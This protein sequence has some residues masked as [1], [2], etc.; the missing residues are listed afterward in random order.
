VVSRLAAHRP[1]TGSALSPGIQGLPRAA[2][3]YVSGA[4]LCGAGVLAW[5]F[6]TQPIQTDVVFLFLVLLSAAL[7]SR[8]VALGQKAEM[9][10]SL[11]LILCAL[12]RAGTGGAIDVAVV[13]M[14]STCL[15]RKKPLA[16]HRTLFNIASVALATL[17]SGA[18]YEALHQQG[19]RFVPSNDLFALAAAV[20]TYFASNTILVAVAIS[21]SNGRPLVHVWAQSFR[22]TLISYLA[23][24]SIAAGMVHLLESYGPYSLILSVP[25]ILLLY[26]F[27]RFYIDRAAEH[28]QRMEEI[29]RHNAE[30]ESEVARRTQE[31][32]E[33]NARLSQ[34]NEDLKR[35]NRLKSEFLANMSHELRTPLNAIIGFSELLQESTFGDLNSDQ[36]AFVR[37]IHAGGQHLLNLINDILDL[38]KIEAGRMSVH[39]E[40]CDLPAILRETLT[41]IR[42]LALKKSLQLE[43]IPAPDASVVWADSGKIK[44]VMYNLLSNAVKFTDTGG[45]ITVDARADG[46]DLVVSVS[47]T[48]I[49]IASDDLLHIFDE[50]YQVDGSLTRRHEGTG[51]GLALV[52]RLIGMHGGDVSVKSRL[53]EGSCFRFR[54]PG[55]VCFMEEPARDPA[56]E[57]TEA[58]PAH[59]SGRGVVMVVE[60]N[61][62]NMRLTRN[63]LACQGF[64]VVEAPS[65]EE[66]LRLLEQQKPD[67]ILMDLQL[68]GVDGLSL[69]R[70]IKSDPQTRDIPTV[71]LTACATDGDEIR[72]LAAGCAGY[73]TKPLSAANLARKIAALLPMKA[74]S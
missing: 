9:A 38:S 41:V 39:R 13:G 20:V 15:L 65:G 49:G 59:G 21:L 28:R 32:V 51:L 64:S 47:D 6:A 53:G 52:K 26:Y 56:E 18:L 40:E 68:P 14:L 44:Q 3:L 37:D 23:G 67:L 73:I 4:I 55:A 31:L 46:K 54:L 48:G 45:L 60:D 61:P 34:S 30:L 36:R 42:P 2:K 17:A 22:W 10:L 25:P 12:M 74:A 7:G 50:F 70:I 19:G 72:V 24:G 62:A 57:V 27:F 1:G 43:A 11:P 71:A 58:L 29:E 33:V 63:I 35:A 69:T 66:A 5:R 16:P 8:T